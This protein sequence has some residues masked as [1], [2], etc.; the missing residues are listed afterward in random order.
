[1]VILLE[2]L[3]TTHPN[4]IPR[5]EI[6][7]EESWDNRE[8]PLTKPE[9]A[10][11]GA[12][13]R[14]PIVVVNDTVHVPDVD[15]YPAFVSSAPSSACVP[16]MLLPAKN[17]S[18]SSSTAS[19]S[20]SAEGKPKFRD[21]IKKRNIKPGFMNPAFY[22]DGQN[23][24]D[25]IQLEPI[26]SKHKP[27][28]SFP[29]DLQ[30]VIPNKALPKYLVHY[31]GTKEG[32]FDSKESADSGISKG[33]MV[34]QSSNEENRDEYYSLPNSEGS[35]VNQMDL[36]QGRSA[37]D[38]STRRKIFHQESLKNRAKAGVHLPDESYVAIAENSPLVIVRGTDS[39]NE[40]LGTSFLHDLN[41]ED[42]RRDN[43]DDKSPYSS[44][45]VV[46]G[47]PELPGSKGALSANSSYF[48][49]Q[50][51]GEESLSEL[52]ELN[53]DESTTVVDNVD[54]NA[55]TKQSNNRK[56][57]TGEI[58]EFGGYHSFQN[59]TVTPEI[60][61]ESMQELQHLQW[62]RNKREID[63]NINV[64]GRSISLANSNSIDR[65]VK[66]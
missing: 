15:P 24:V 21:H 52:G 42:K 17:L 43:Q 36:M 63:Q 11:K 19:S 50:G 9:R 61:N 10:A 22:D 26:R 32:V 66:Y 35:S 65:P 57:A 3:N 18:R 62:K 25:G 64:T 28:K 38:A 13:S 7:E 30:H 8:K 47:S 16:S 60:G 4:L 39:E 54:A 49:I 56:S 14:H 31:S 55:N 34:H 58:A 59:K 45:F 53:N 48:I 2:I 20:S 33:S 12:Q 6:S 40:N 44:P 29:E 5:R 1:M 27:P 51:S 46:I 41:N 23:K 37:L